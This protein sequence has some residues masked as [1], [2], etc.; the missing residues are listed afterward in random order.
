MPLPRSC[1]SVCLS[2]CS[3]TAPR[4]EGLGQAV[5]CE[6]YIQDQGINT[7]CRLQN[8]SQAEYKELSICVNGS[9]AATL[10]RPLYVTLRLQDLGKA[11]S[12]QPPHPRPAKAHTW[13][14][15]AQSKGCGGLGC[16]CP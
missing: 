15:G 16:V 4:Y 1:L 2:V 8:L 14:E 10:L 7:G 5:Q 3:L 6:D 9:G 12:R 11:G 13:R